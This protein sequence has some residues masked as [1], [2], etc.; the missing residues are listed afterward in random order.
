MVIWKY[1][2]GSVINLV[3]AANVGR[4]SDQIFRVV[5]V[6]FLLIILFDISHQEKFFV[7][8]R[9]LQLPTTEVEIPQIRLLLEK[10]QCKK[11][12]HKKRTLLN[13]FI[14][15]TEPKNMQNPEKFLPVYILKNPI[16][17]ETR[18][19]KQFYH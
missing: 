9:I 3:L 17:K 18:S 11:L 15:H 16:Y 8:K 1:D 7:N 14:Y 19:D 4:M 13:K 12:K 2:W 5:W 10:D 6:L